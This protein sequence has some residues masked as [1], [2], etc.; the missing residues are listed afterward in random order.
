M[1][2]ILPLQR[3]RKIENPIPIIQEAMAVI[4]VAEV[5]VDLEEAPV[6]PEAVDK[7]T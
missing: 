4:A 2:K 5:M 7:Y 6:D 1:Q 3:V